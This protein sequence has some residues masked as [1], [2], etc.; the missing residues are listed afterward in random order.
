MERA[1]SQEKTTKN[2][3]ENRQGQHTIF[4]IILR[5]TATK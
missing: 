3:M 4:G 5:I 2:T 1:K